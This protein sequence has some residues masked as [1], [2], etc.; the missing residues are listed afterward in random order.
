MG[1]T[2]LSETTKVPFVAKKQAPFKKRSF[3]VKKKQLKRK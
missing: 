3:S 2:I 1:E